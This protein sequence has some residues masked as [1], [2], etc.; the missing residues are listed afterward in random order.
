MSDSGG[1]AKTFETLMD[2]LTSCATMETL[3][4]R[5]LTANGT[6]KKKKQTTVKLDAQISNSIGFLK[7]T[8]S[9]CNDSRKRDRPDVEIDSSDAEL[10]KLAR[11]T[12]CM[13]LKPFQAF[14]QYVPRLV[15][16]V[17]LAEAIPVPGSGVTLPLDLALIA[18]RCSGAYF[19]PKRFSAVQL[20]YTNPRARVL[21]FH[22]GR[23]VG[24]GTNGPMAA[25]LAISRAQHQL[26]TEAGVRLHTKNFA[27]INQV[28]ACSLNATL[29]C[30]QFANAHPHDAHFDQQSFVGLAWRPARECICCEVYST[31]RANLPGS[32]RERNLQESWARMLPELLRFS[33]RSR[34]LDLIPDSLKRAHFTQNNGGRASIFTDSLRPKPPEAGLLDGWDG[35]GSDG[36]DFPDDHLAALGL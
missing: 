4:S 14:L 35:A 21:I 10:S 32:T 26:S 28:G 17:T 18:S 12:D 1:L 36:D 9:H 30:D 24:T 19:A 20:A 7:S 15:N 3:A 2:D 25:R 27:I 5:K 29:E 8:V 22:T 6:P 34:L 33:S 23:L 31:G 13:G 16:V 11:F